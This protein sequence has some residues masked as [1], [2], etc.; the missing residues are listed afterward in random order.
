MKPHNHRSPFCSIT[1]S[2]LAAL[3]AVFVGAP[4]AGAVAID[5]NQTFDYTSTTAAATTLINWSALTWN[6]T[7][8][9]GAG[10]TAGIPNGASTT[11]LARTYNID[12]AD[13][14]LKQLQFYNADA[15]VLQGGVITW[16]AGAAGVQAELGR[17]RHTMTTIAAGRN[18]TISTPFVLNSNLRVTNWVEDRITTYNSTTS[19]N[20]KL[21]L[22]LVPWG[23]GTSTLNIGGTAANTHTGGT[24][25][26][27]TGA[28]MTATVNKSDAF[29]T[30]VLTLD[31]GGEITLNLNNFDQTVAG[32]ASSGNGAHT[33]KN[34][35][36]SLKT[37]TLKLADGATTTF[38]K[39]LTGANLAL[40]VD[41]ATAATGTGVQVLTGANT[42]TGGTTVTGGTLIGTSTAALGSG[43][44]LTLGSGAVF[45]Y[46]PAAAGALDV[47]TGG[48]TFNDGSTIGTALGGTASQSALTSTGAAVATGG[49]VTVDIWGIPGVVP[50]ADAND[51]IT[52]ASGL[53]GGAA[54]TLGKVYNNS[55]FTV[56]P[57]ATTPTAVR[58]AVTLVSQLPAAYWTGGLAG[59]PNVWA[60]SNGSTISNWVATSGGASQPL[61]P[62]AATEVF[63]S[64]SAVTTAPTA[65]VL[66]ANMTIASLT[67]ADTV[68]GLVLNSDGNT[69]TIGTPAGLTMKA[70]VPASVIAAK[71]ALG[72]DQTWTNDSPE[73][74][75]VSGVVSGGANTLTKAGSGILALTGANTYTGIT[76][77]TAG[78]LQ[79]NKTGGQAIAGHLQVSGGT[80]KLLQASQLAAS[81]GLVVSGGTFDLQTFNQ[82]LAGV[83]LTGG[84]LIG[85][86]GILTSNAVFDLQAGAVSANLAGNA[87]LIKTTDGSVT[88]SGLNTCTGPTTI[89]GG[90]LALS[91]AGAIASSAINIQTGAILDVSALGGWTVGTTQTLTG[92]GTLIG[93]TTTSG[94]V[95]PGAV[96]GTLAVT[97]GFTFA[98]GSSLVV[99]IDEGF[100]QVETATAVGTATATGDVLVTVVDTSATLAALTVPVLVDETADV[101]AG[102]VRTALAAEPTITARYRVGGTGVTIA[103]TR[104]T[105]DADDALLNL[106]LTNG[107][108]NPGII[109]ATA[110]ANTTAG[111]A[112]TGNDR[113]MVSGALDI[114]GATLDLA[115]T[116]TL[117]AP[118]YVIATYG[119]LT[120]P[121][122]EVS[123]T[124]LPAGYVIDYAYSGGTAI[125]I[126]RSAGGNTYAE[127]LAANPPATGFDTDSDRDGNANGIEHLL[128]TSP[129]SY[130]AGLTQVAATATSVTFRHALNPT[131]ANDVAASY[132]WSTDLVEWKASGETNSGGT[133]AT[134][135]PSAPVGG[136][137]T[138][139]TTITFGPTG[140]LFG[141]LVA[142]KVP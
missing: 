79:L 66:G 34:S 126:K 40:L 60:V 97:G 119:S 123:G 69:L 78:E 87:A 94:I 131:V 95:S 25:L 44:G 35:G 106:A 49:M 130:S 6:G 135:I 75:T 92:D 31:G 4:H 109:P 142:T 50:A 68:N 137:V 70:N 56:S 81:K 93:T 52:S 83:Q 10:V 53:D 63:I 46:R 139:T 32:L 26:T 27:M 80:A 13:L 2:A 138:V 86:G 141:R 23:A 122:A 116:G 76:E 59:V 120:R 118:A 89:T 107:L 29:G 39:K 133:T 20:G 100:A 11:S 125:A 129:N 30:G 8:T 91:G 37:L 41:K 84:S 51:L 134:I 102:K 108:A 96:V 16:D 98:T 43:G 72:T 127:W 58:T 85:S 105:A 99:E 21:T 90:T 22:R 64:S 14:T 38:D 101:W 48:L 61:V 74:L 57:L 36:A 113:F 136:V 45:A 103:L 111:A 67:I 24:T 110:S 5:V 104:L 1:L 82:T 128:G 121:F 54:F 115:I 47:G 112:P 77:V 132:Q 17:N 73:T 88:L 18:F 71:V 65:T 7:P 12:V 62:G 9:W 114:S 140:K 3:A 28:K 19:G 117:S 124:P 33:L 42:H 15:I 55:D